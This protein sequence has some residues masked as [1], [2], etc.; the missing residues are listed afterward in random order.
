M[1]QSRDFYTILG[2]SKDS[3]ADTIK[4]AYRRLAMQFHPDKNPGNSEAEEKFKEAAS[5]YEVLSNPEKK[6]Q[7]DRFGHAAYTQQGRGG[8]G[9][10]FADMEDIF[11]QFG[12][13][14]GDFFG[15]GQGGGGRGRSQRNGPRRGA[16]LRYMTEISLKDVI[17]GLQKEI[18]FDTESNCETCAGSGA[19]KGA[20]VKTC[21]GCGGSGQVL[22]RQ[23]FFSMA[24]TC[25]TCAGR[26]QIIEKPCKTCKGRGRTKQHRKISLTVPAGV[27]TGTRLRV[28]NEGEGGY[29]GGPNGDLYVEISVREDERF[30]RSG[31]D[32]YTRLDVDYLQLLLGGVVQV[33]TVTGKED[34]DVPRGTQVGDKIRISGQG[35][36]S[37]RGSRRGDLFCLVGVEF[38]E[39]LSKDEEK[40]LKELAELRGISCGTGGALSGLFGRKK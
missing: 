12:D 36:P 3:D 32:L 23:G 20:G 9:Q 31:N 35:I 21:N 5:A 30:E 2:V 18:E 39:K 34:V 7:Y 16:D 38:P 15:G 27:D 1:S 11:S 40:L 22:S 28:S 33:E 14:F 17:E 25:P 37:L 6:A 10:G 4:K 19:D 29:Q 8:G 26:G 13:I 24:T